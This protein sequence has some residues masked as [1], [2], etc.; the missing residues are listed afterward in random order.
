MRYAIDLRSKTG[1][2]G[3][4]SLSFSH[5]E[6]APSNVQEKIVAEHAKEKAEAEK[7]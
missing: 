2:R 4:F 1:G 6:E 7:K 5:Y 3:N